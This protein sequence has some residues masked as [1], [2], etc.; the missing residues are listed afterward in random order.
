[1]HP[2]P[3]W[4]FGFLDEG[5]DLICQNPWGELWEASLGAFPN[6]V[7]SRA[8]AQA[9]ILALHGKCWRYA[10]AY[11]L[12][13]NTWLF[14]LVPD[15]SCH[16]RP[17]SQLLGCVTT[18]TR[19]F[20]LP[21]LTCSCQWGHCPLCLD[22]VLSFRFALQSTILLLLLDND[23]IACISFQS[24]NTV[25]QWSQLAHLSIKGVPGSLVSSCQGLGVGHNFIM[26]GSCCQDEGDDET[27]LEMQY[28]PGIMS[29][30]NEWKNCNQNTWIKPYGHEP[31]Y[32]IENSVFQ[33]EDWRQ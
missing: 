10:C 26:E 5:L 28:P 30:C 2:H 18:V 6:S 1:M 7:G 3:S 29:C 25:G 19:L 22:A 23:I 13:P 17:I 16:Y 8:K 9:L 11:L 32:I 24:L 14:V 33:H 27:V 21:S 20:L 31:I 12:G 15:I 4:E